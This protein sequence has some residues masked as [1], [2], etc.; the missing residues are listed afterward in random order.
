[1]KSVRPI[2]A[3]ENKSNDLSLGEMSRVKLPRLQKP[4]KKV[5]KPTLK[6][7]RLES[8][9]S[10]YEQLAEEIQD[11]QN[12]ISKKYGKS[13]KFD[14]LKKMQ[15]SIT[16][17]NQDMNKINK[18]LCIKSAK[19]PCVKSTSSSDVDEVIPPTKHLSKWSK[20]VLFKKRPEME[21]KNLVVVNFEGV[22]GDVYKDNIW[23]D[24]REKIHKRKGVCKGLKD[25]INNFQ[26]VLFFHT[27]RINYQKILDFLEFKNIYFDAVYVSENSTQWD[28]NSSGRFKKPLKYSEYFQNY[29]QI[30]VDFGIQHDILGK[31]LVLTSACIDTD[32]D[33]SPNIN[34]L[35]KNFSKIPQYLW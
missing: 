31:M 32:E 21:N 17:L 24:Q 26:V 29:F 3:S 5:K 12:C 25:L 4:L 6:G 18:N 28:K 35:I 9:P 10:K 19:E 15:K 2:Q 13:I 27:Q 16:S 33:F 23:V 30:S 20:R 8:T 14:C 22:I 1:M 34:I 11:L 7:N